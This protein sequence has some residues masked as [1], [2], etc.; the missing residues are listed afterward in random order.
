[1]R[2]RGFSHGL[3]GGPA[4]AH[5][6]QA[7]GGFVESVRGV[8]QPPVL[9]ESVAP[10]RQE[11]WSSLRVVAGEIERLPVVPLGQDDVERQGV[12]AGQLEGADGGL[13]Q[14]T[15]QVVVAGSPG[16]FESGDV[17]VSQDLGDLLQPVA[18]GRLHPARHGGVLGGSVGPGELPVGDVADE[19]VAKGELA[20]TGH[21]G[22]EMAAHEIALHEVVQ[23]GLGGR[24]VAVVESGD[25]AGPEDLADHGRVAEERLVGRGQLVE[26]SRDQRLQ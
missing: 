17:V 16:Q 23:R 11:V 10:L 21:R 6:K 22:V 20:L 12:V 13:S 18:G 8:L 3:C 15:P 26:A 4:A 25:G 14:L 9:Q 7:A 1:M 19:R 24:V 5:V 2:V